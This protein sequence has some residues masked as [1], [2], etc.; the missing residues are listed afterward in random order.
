MTTRTLIL[1]LLVTALPFAAQNSPRP[2]AAD[3][4]PQSDVLKL[5]DWRGH[6][7]DNPAWASPNFDDASWPQSLPPMRS[8]VIDVPSGYRWYRATV[9][10][11]ASLQGRPLA[12]GMGAMEEVYEVYVEGVSVGRFGHWQPSPDGPFARSVYFSIPAAQIHGTTLHIAIRRWIG[13]SNTNIVIFYASGG[14]RFIHPP[15][16]GPES[17]IQDRAELY[18]YVGFFFGLPSNLSMLLLIAAGGIA[19]VLFSAQRQR[20]EYFFLGLYCAGLPI[21]LFS[22]ALLATDDSVMMR[23]PLP[24]ACMLLYCIAQASALLFLSRVTPRFRHWLELGAAIDFSVRAL[25]AYALLTQSVTANHL[26][27]S[28][29]FY[30]ALVFT[31]LASVGLFLERKPGSVAIGLAILL[32]QLSEAWTAFIARW[33]NLPNLRN[34]AVGPFTIDLRNICD[35]IMVTVILTVLYRRFRDEQTQTVIYEQDMAS[36][37]RMQQQ[38]LA[39]KSLE[40]PGFHVDAVYRPAKLVGG[41]FYRTDLVDDGSLLIV[42]GDVS[43]KGLDAALL[44]SA[45]LGG[46]AI[47]REQNP[48][49]LLANLNNAVHG[50]TAGGFITAC[51]ARLYPDGRLTVANAG[52]IAPYLNGKELA[53]EPGLPLGIVSGV[54]YSESFFA[55]GGHTITWLS[56]GVLEAQNASGELLGFDRMTALTVKSATEIADAAQQWGQED[57]ITVLTVTLLPERNEAV[58]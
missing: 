56:D 29:A 38:M 18:P 48:G 22:G 42:V 50:R 2:T 46:L 16:L 23:S 26:F 32:R 43:G 15:E 28:I 49:T 44:V 36:A 25:G 51:C 17:T 12:I 10:L 40:C 1:F 30:P 11:P 3:L 39:D 8:T 52:H 9:T 27:W 58:A 53:V 33:L 47:D 5:T 7:G 54:A 14:N 13:G 19:F 31:S 41:D 4:P 35:I 37:R 20:S 6:S 21:S 55:T 57:D 34:I 24:A 45:V